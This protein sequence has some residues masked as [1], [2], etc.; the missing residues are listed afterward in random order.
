M[1]KNNSYI[2]ADHIRTA[3][4]CIADGV[5]PG[6]KQRAYILRRLIR[7][8]LSASLQIGIDIGQIGYFQELVDTVI[9]IYKGVYDE[10]SDNREVIVKTIFGEAQK[11]QKAIVIGQ[12]E[13]QK[14]LKDPTLFDS[15]KTAAIA[16]N[17]YQSAGVPFEV[18]EDVCQKNDLDFDFNLVEKLQT[19][20]QNLSRTTSVGQF[21]SGLGENNDKTTRLHTT[22]H[23]LHQVLRD[24]FG[25]NVQ[26]KGSAITNEKA[27]FDFTLEHKIQD[28]DL[29][30]IQ[31]KVQAIID[32]NLHM[33]IIQTTQV[34]ATEMGAIGLFGEKYGDKVSVYLLV[35]DMGKPFSKEFCTGP[36][37]VNT[38]EIGQ[39][40]ILKEKSVSAGVRRLEFNVN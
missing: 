10:L 20:H 19:E 17:L 27:R 24:V 4:F 39:F 23:I 7:R 29:Q 13:W 12:K 22:T 28:Q 14:L 38:S 40:I 5:Q 30:S 2:I 11:Y 31:S 9:G 37:V 21:K 1:T 34:A 35:D 6:G 16:W 33:K 18:S 36:H 26:Q 32:K 8:S 25:E 3:C 15:Q